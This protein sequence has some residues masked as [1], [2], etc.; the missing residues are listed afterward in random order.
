MAEPKILSALKVKASLESPAFT[1]I[2]TVPTAANG[3]NN[4]QIAST[5]FVASTLGNYSSTDT[6][7]TAG[8]TNLTSTKLYVIGATSQEANP[9][10]YSNSSVYISANNVLMGAAWNDF[11]EFR[12][13]NIQEPGRV[14]CENGDG[15]LSLATERFQSG[16]EIISDTFGFAIGETEFCK[17]PVA[18]AG[19]V[20]A[21]PYEDINTYSAGDAVCAAPGG[22]VSR[23]TRE[24][25]K[26]YPDRIIG[27]VSEIPTYKYWNETE[28]NGRI[29]I[30]I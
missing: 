22:T 23:M 7:N 14:I 19:R 26:E 30:K 9:Q 25:V 2:P 11:A 13:S 4:T 6:K 17:T 20:L 15:T 5:A 27:T 1:G 24:E 16:A 10:T 21:F 29:W 8:S 18:I 3:T 28:V 12:R